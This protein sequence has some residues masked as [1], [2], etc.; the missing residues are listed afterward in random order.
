VRPALARVAVGVVLRRPENR[1]HRGNPR[2]PRFD[3]A[4]ASRPGST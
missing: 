4:A 1:L 2:L 3:W